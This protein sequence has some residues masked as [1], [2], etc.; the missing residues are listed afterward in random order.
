MTKADGG[1]ALIYIILA[2][3]SLIV[4]AIGKSK[5]KG[6]HQAP[7][8]P[9]PSEQ[10]TKPHE[11]EVT[12]QKEL[13]DIFGKVFTEPEVSTQIPKNESAP[14]SSKKEVL[15]ENV[16]TKVAELNKYAKFKEA[17]VE[18][19]KPTKH[20]EVIEEEERSPLASVEDFDLSM[21]VVYTE[22][23]NRKYF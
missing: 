7:P 4:S 14:V 11:P 20:L 12:W 9:G 21:A 5:S 22:V 3:I 8:A 19:D 17:K 23:L 16:D 2:V 6:T 13:E 1:G 18:E 10:E 15:S